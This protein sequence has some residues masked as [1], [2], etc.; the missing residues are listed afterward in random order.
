MAK[1]IV[2]EQWRCKELF[3]IEFVQILERIVVEGALNGDI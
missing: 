2:S 1:I 3:Q